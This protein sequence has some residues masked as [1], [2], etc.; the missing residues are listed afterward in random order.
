MSLPNNL[1][2]E[3]SL[4]KKYYFLLMLFVAMAAGIAFVQ[5]GFEGKLL[6]DDSIYIYSGQQ[7]A[8]G[9]PPYVS[10]F[11]VKGPLSPILCGIAVMVGRTQGANDIFSCRALFFGISIFV[12]IAIFLLSSKVFHSALNALFASMTFAT[13]WGFGV[14]AASGPRAKT[15]MVLFEILALYFTISQKWFTAGIFGGLAVLV[16]QPM[17]VFPAITFFLA[18][19]QSSP[20]RQRLK[21]G[22]LAIT[23][24]LFPILLV[25]AWFFSNNALP[26]FLDGWITFHVNYMDRGGANI[27][28]NLLNILNAVYFGYPRA[29]VSVWMGFLGIILFFKK[30]LINYDGDLIKLVQKDQNAA[31]FLSFPLPFVWSVL[32]FQGYA[33]FY[34]FLP[35]AALG[36]GWILSATAIPA[37]GFK[38][39]R[40]AFC[41]LIVASLF[42]FGAM[43][44]YKTRNTVLMDQ[45]EWA[46][47]IESELTKEDK[48]VS[49]GIPEAL[50]LMQRRNPTP[51]VFIIAGIDSYIEDK[52]VGGFDGWIRNMDRDKPTII[53]FG[54]TWGR[55]IPKLKKWLNKYYVNTKVG[56][57]NVY[58]IRAKDNDQRN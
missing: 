51:Y 6:R 8:E 9:V 50:V 21:N 13:F 57:W 18:I 42:V 14:H 48:V 26:N 29:L 55:Q 58:R 7:M 25:M 19:V 20:S 41:V 56:E 34:P 35:Y 16:W 10:I 11:D 31:L 23:G 3:T 38:G 30:A 4:P 12:I 24:A 36:F 39:T 2:L 28:G 32:D 53:L 37:E 17:I 1:P 43:S 5:S 45:Q 54:S 46:S 40:K 49:I 15:P 22:A 44:Y 52:T 27:Q 47:K 33:D